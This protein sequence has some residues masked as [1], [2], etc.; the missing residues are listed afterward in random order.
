MKNV[1][2]ITIEVKGKEWEEALDKAFKKKKKDIKID[3]FRK[4]SVTKEIYIKKVGIE[5]LFM[6]ACDI[7][8]EDAYKQ[9]YKELDME[10][11]VEPS[12]DIVKLDKKGVTFKITFIGR[13]E[14]KLGAYKKLGIKQEK[15][16]VTKEEIEH[17][18]E[19][20]REHMAEVVIK[21]KG[22]IADGNTA[23]ID[24]EGYIDGEQ[25]DGGTGA[26][27]PLE[28]G[29]HTFIP[30]FEEQVIGMKVGETKDINVTFPEDY[31]EEMKGK[32]ATFKVTV[33]E[34][35]ERVKPEIDSDF[36]EDLGIEGVDSLDKLK[37]HLE[38]DLKKS[39]ERDAEDKFLDEALR[40]ATDNMEVE[41]N[42]E[43]IDA[44]VDMM[45]KQ[46]NQELKL[47]G[48][49]FE[50]YCQFTGKTVDEVKVMIRPQAIV[51]IK[52]RLLLEEI[53]KKEEIEVTDEEVKEE[54]K[55]ALEQYNID[56]KEFLELTGG[57]KAIEY[58][59]TAK[60]ALDVIK[61]G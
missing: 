47:Q 14:V 60:K 57:K 50:Q 1:K 46:Y 2:E 5:A 45:I 44:E 17:E 58:E 10:I 56:E 48:L 9:A 54:I 12:I 20:L 33:R 31:V 21:E 32:D 26:N 59:L 13:P 42:E 35:R 52:V 8:V 29:S 16:K 37:E 36:F 4:G 34:I 53:A 23:V 51:R 11:V 24:F 18:I 38:A 39:K 28:I 30:G 27:Y 6:D 3:G 40:I 41:I 61:E 49:T 19:H 43:I 22:T 15:V 7:C 25:F 55:K